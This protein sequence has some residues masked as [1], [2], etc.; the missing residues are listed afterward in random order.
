LQEHKTKGA[1]LAMLAFTKVV[2]E[3]IIRHKNKE[4]FYHHFNVI[5][6]VVPACHDHDN[7]NP[8]CHS[9]TGQ[10]L[11]YVNWEKAF[12]IEVP[13]P[14]SRCTGIL[15]S[16]R[17]NFSKN[18]TLFPIFGLDGPPLWCVVMVYQCP[19][20]RRTFKASNADMLNNMPAHAAEAY[21]VDTVYALPTVCHINRHATEAFASIMVTYGNG[22]ICS[23]LLLNTLNRDYLRRLKFYYS[24]GVLKKQQ[25]ADATVPSYVDKDGGFIRQWPPLGDSIRDIAIP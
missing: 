15:K 24:I 8:H 25:N 2:E 9:I 16:D 4:L 23:K 11:L 20:C 14:D 10:K 19:C 1:P 18:K 22:E 17:S 5:E 13:C 21:P 12:G 7:L 3:R 6:M